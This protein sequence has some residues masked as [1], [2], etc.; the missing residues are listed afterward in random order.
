MNI[1]FAASE[2]APLAKVGGLA[3]VVGSLPKALR[4]LGTDVRIAL[5]KYDV[6]DDTKFPSKEITTF[7]V[8]FNGEN[9]AITIFQT[10][11]P[12]SDVPVYLLDHPSFFSNGG[13]YIEADASSGGSKA[14]LNRFGLFSRA[15]PELFSAIDWQPNLIHCHDWQ[16]GA[17]PTLIRNVRAN[18]RSPLQ[19]IK[20][21]FTI[22]NLAYQGIHPRADA[23]RAFD[24]DLANAL[25]QHPYNPNEIN[26]LASAITHADRISTV[27]PTYAQ[28]ISTPEFG[29]GLD[30]LLKNL[31]HPP[32]GI[33]NGI[34]TEYWNPATDQFLA[35]HFTNA[36]EAY[37]AK[38]ALKKQLQTEL[39]FP[40]SEPAPFLVIVS[41]LTEQKGFDIL[42]PTLEEL[43]PT[44]NFQCV[45]LAAGD[46]KFAAPLHALAQQFPHKLHFAERFDEPFAHRLYAAGDFFLMPSRF[47]PCGLGQMIAMRYGSIPI[48]TAVGGLYDTVKDGYTGFVVPSYDASALVAT[49][50]R[51]LAQYIEQ[52]TSLI[53]LREN[54]MRNNF[55]WTHSAKEYGKLYQEIVNNNQA[56]RNKGTNN[57]Q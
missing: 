51:A 20:T 28:E 41:R 27:S 19:E 17:I 34:D 44:K 55:S 47:E 1:L 40:V 43:L 48:A 37:Q 50:E 32:V 30:E 54:G 15:I 3:D 6:I 23:T 10:N 26:F 56:T 16:T 29:N 7:T 38:S 24:H 13:V 39:Q 18:G 14:E 12:G 11:L 4:Q 52:P 42:I 36:E 31:P 9:Q 21:L 57:N 2:C 5:P 49:I 45:I 53:Q 35:L 25:T 8:P 46:K 33:V 22:H